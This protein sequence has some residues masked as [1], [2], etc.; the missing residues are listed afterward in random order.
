M[1]VFEFDEEIFS[2]NSLAAKLGQGVHLPLLHRRCLLKC[3]V[4]GAG[5]NQMVAAVTCK[6][7]HVT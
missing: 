1:I 2:F 3:G 4:E 7:S 6:A 5:W